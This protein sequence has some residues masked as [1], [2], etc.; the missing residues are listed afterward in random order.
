MVNWNVS[1]CVWVLRSCWRPRCVCV[2][3]CV[4]IPGYSWAS[5]ACKAEKGPVWLF[6]WLWSVQFR[7]NDDLKPLIPQTPAERT[8]T[9]VMNEHTA[10]SFS[11]IC[12]YFCIFLPS[13]PNSCSLSCL[14]LLFNKHKSNKAGKEACFRLLRGALKRDVLSPLGYTHTL[15]YCCDAFTDMFTGTAVGANVFLKC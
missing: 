10:T 4:R 7:L 13:T 1:A 5:P 9:E 8:L 12:A 6:T 14:N 11:C 15:F 3:V 2:C